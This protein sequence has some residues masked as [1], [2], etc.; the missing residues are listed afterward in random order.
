[1]SACVFFGHKDSYGLD[2]GVLQA[3]IEEWIL[4]GVDTFYVG[5]QGQFDT[6]AYSCLKQ[7]RK[8]HPHICINVVLE[9]LPGE[10]T[11]QKDMEDTIFPEGLESAPPRFAIDRRNTWM[12]RQADHCLCYINHTWGGAYK[13]ARMAKRKGLK[14]INLGTVEF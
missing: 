8:R 13:F 12:V 10:N 6:M 4:Q 11:E 1:M 5:S 2:S 14:I 7:L 3:A 9:H